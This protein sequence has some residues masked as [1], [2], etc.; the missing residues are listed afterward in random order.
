MAISD[1]FFSGS[2]DS[3]PTEMKGASGTPVFGGYILEEENN[4][5][6]TGRQKYKT[7]TNILINTA[8]VSAGVR[9]FLNTLSKPDWKV[10]PATDTGNDALAEQ[11]AEL[12]E[13]MMSDM[14][15]PWHR[16]VRRSAMYRFYGFSIQEWNAKRREDGF[17]GM[18]D[19]A[20]R[21]QITIERWDTDDFGKVIGAIQRHPKFQNEI[22]L[23]REKIIY[24]VDDTLNDSPEGAGLFRS[25]VDAAKRL[26]RFEELEAFGFETDLRGIPIARIPYTIIDQMVKA[27]QLTEADGK[28]MTASLETFIKKHIKNPQLGIALDSQPYESVGDTTRVS[29]VLQW[30]VELLSGDG[31]NFEAVNTAIER[32][33]H[34]IARL[35]GVENLLLGQ[36]RGTQALSKDKSQNFGLIVDST[37]A[38]IRE[39]YEVDFLN[40][41]FDLNGWD[42]KLKP[43]FQIDKVQYRDIEEVT[44]ALRDM[45]QAGAVL[46]LDDEAINEV[47]DLLGLSHAPEIDE[48]DLMI[49]TVVPPEEEVE[50]E[51]LSEETTEN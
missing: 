51:E 15:T 10:L 49:P 37:L 5:K 25:M 4:S 31:G 46:A 1:F 20:P 21:P 18:E 7:Y 48:G 28:K 27:G 13:N 8:I 14:E 19:I 33:N 45:A 17:L 22:Y 38:E 36:S 2:K 24:L 29:N 43:S 39:S 12:V 34:E 50:E 3:K 32:I 44:G 9:Y 16:V 41:I 23:P 42:R 40:P 35:L 11:Y 47:R 6:L 26:Q 30:N